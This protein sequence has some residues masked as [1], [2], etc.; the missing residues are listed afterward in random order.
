MAILH[1]V[2]RGRHFDQLDLFLGQAQLFGDQPG[3]VGHAL[4]VG[5]GAGVTE[6]D[7]AGQPRQRF[8][9][10]LLDLVHAGQQALFQRHRPLLHVFGLLAQLQEVVAAC[11]QFA[12]PDRL[13]QEV[14]HPGFERGLAD[15]F[16]AD[17][18]NQDH[19]DVAVLGQAAEPTGELQPV[20][21]R[22]A[23]IQQQQVHPVRFAPGQRGERVAEIMHAQFGRD[24]LD[25]MPQHRA[26]G[27][28][29]VND[30]NIQ[31]CFRRVSGPHWNVLRKGYSAALNSG[32][33]HGTHLRS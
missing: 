16:V 32:T 33:L 20:H 12:R 30:D 26:R 8:A 19:R 31:G 23:V 7:R 22:H 27:R 17:H 29:I 6:L 5:A 21:F 10:A 14:D 1:V 4:Q 11:A 28:L 3:H 2:Q 13:D 9:L 24:V 15:R 25:D 18:G